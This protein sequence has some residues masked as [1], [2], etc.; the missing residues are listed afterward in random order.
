MS[1]GDPVHFEIRDHSTTAAIDATLYRS[2]STD[3]I[4][5]GPTEILVIE[6]LNISMANTAA[7]LIEVYLG[8]GASA[9]NG[10]LVMSAE[11]ATSILPAVQHTFSPPRSGKPGAKLRAIHAVASAFTLTGTGYLSKA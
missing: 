6:S 5:L 1:T 4:V 10:E 11:S 2:A 3:P 7:G 9:A 8:N